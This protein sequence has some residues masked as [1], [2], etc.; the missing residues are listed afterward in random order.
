MAAKQLL[1]E[2]AARQSLL[3]GVQKLSRAV[4]VTLGSGGAVVLGVPLSEER[5]ATGA[6]GVLSPRTHSPCVAQ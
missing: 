5:Y 6:G 4:A 3:R 1:F 2:E